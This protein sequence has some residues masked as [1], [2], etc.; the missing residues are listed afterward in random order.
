MWNIGGARVL[1]YGAAV[2][3]KC[4]CQWDAM[5]HVEHLAA[6]ATDFR[7]LRGLFF[8]TP[9]RAGGWA[10][11]CKVDPPKIGK[12]R[13]LSET[14]PPLASEAPRSASKTRSS[15]TTIGNRA[16]STS[17][18]KNRTLSALDDDHIIYAF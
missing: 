10:G 12:F 16:S 5:F 11:F 18:S 17:P 6:P 7:W 8:I 13:K 4:R 2:A 3:L 9:G 14:P 1:A 15:R